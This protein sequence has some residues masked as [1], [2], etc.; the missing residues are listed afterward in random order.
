MKNRRNEEPS[1]PLSQP[2]WLWQ[3]SW[4]RYSVVKNAVGFD[5]GNNSG[6]CP[7]EST[8]SGAVKATAMAAAVVVIT[9]R[10]VSAR[11]LGTAF[12]C[13]SVLEDYPQQLV[14]ELYGLGMAMTSLY[15][16]SY[17]GLG[18]IGIMMIMVA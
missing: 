4:Q 11:I 3:W 6:P 18:S 14:S 1:R 5:N 10:F 2:L 8:E 17:G 7:V 9:T 13:S 12:P 16:R 15:E